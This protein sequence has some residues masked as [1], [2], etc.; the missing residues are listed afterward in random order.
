MIRS[1][2]K[3]TSVTIAALIFFGIMMINS[4]QSFAASGKWE[5]MIGDD[6]YAGNPMFH[7]VEVLNTKNY[8]QYA[9]VTKARKTCGKKFNLDTR[10][11]ND[12]SKDYRG[13]K[14]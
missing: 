7:N 1:I 12:N 8:E 6:C 10:T 5:F 14:P 2:Q 4:G 9:T 11:G 13:Q 3:F